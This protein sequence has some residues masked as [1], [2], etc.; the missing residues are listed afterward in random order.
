[1]AAIATELNVL[2]DATP[3]D[4]RRSDHGPSTSRSDDPQRADETGTS[5]GERI[6]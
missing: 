4:S 2:A 3:K 6:Y 5:R 1:M